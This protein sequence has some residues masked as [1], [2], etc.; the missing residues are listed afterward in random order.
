MTNEQCRHMHYIELEFDAVVCR[1]IRN[2]YGVNIIPESQMD[3][4]ET[5]LKANGRTL[6]MVTG[7]GERLRFCFTPTFTSDEMERMT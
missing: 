1:Q 2:K 3:A 7:K 4:V 5:W 6:T